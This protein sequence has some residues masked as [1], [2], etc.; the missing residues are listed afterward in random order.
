MPKEKTKAP[1]Q[2]SVACTQHTV[3]TTQ[4]PVFP[5]QHSVAPTQN[6]VFPTQHSVAPA[7]H[8]DTHK[9][10]SHTIHR[11]QR[12]V[13]FP[14]CRVRLNKKSFKIHCKRKHTHHFETVSKDRFLACQCVD[15]I[16][17]VFAAEK[18]FCGV[19]TPPLH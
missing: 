17:G 16:H 1:A 8:S 13:T 5:T 19:T 2:P 7:E 4:N 6:P 9:T 10:Y 15:V 11:K 18:S 3:A 12:M 14:H